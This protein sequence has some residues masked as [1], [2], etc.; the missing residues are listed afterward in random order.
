MPK[1]SYVTSKA[2]RRS[3]ALETLKTIPRL[4]RVE[5]P[6][7]RQFAAAIGVSPATASKR[8]DSPSE[9]T[10]EEL[11]TASINLGYSGSVKLQR[12]GVT[13]EVTW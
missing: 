11:I 8:L 12:D 2:A 3:K 4:F 6:T 5:C 9:L 10:L 7:C 1:I 13:A